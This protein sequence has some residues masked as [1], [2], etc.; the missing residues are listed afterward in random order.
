MAPRSWPGKSAF[1]FADRRLSPVRLILTRAH[2]STLQKRLDTSVV[3]PLLFEG[4]SDPL[5]TSPNDVAE[6]ALT[7]YAESKV[8]GKTLILVVGCD[9]GA[10]GSASCSTLYLR[11]SLSGS[12]C[13]ARS[14][15]ASAS[16]VAW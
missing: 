4:Q 5:F 9:S 2:A 8:V 11:L 13:Q 16:S 14:P 3:Q 10:R 15:Q 1:I 12:I 7:V 6:P